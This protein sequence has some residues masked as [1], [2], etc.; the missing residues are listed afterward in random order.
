MFF[1]SPQNLAE[2]DKLG[3]LK[4][5][6]RNDNISIGRIGEYIDAVRMLMRGSEVVRIAD[7]AGGTTINGCPLYTSFRAL[8]GSGMIEL[9]VPSFEQTI[10]HLLSGWPPRYKLNSSG[11]EIAEKMLA[12]WDSLPWWQRA[13]LR[14]F[15]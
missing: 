15:R 2:R 4:Q 7:C 13:A 1:E 9:V 10:E 5:N 3:T 8:H 6:S 12:S 14:F 11:I